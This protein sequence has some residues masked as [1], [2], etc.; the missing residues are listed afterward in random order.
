MPLNHCIGGHSWSSGVERKSGI[1]DETLLRID[2]VM[3]MSEHVRT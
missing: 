3:G 2:N 1:P